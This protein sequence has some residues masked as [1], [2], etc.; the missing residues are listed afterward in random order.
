MRIKT[1]ISTSHILIVL[2]SLALLALLLAV[3]VESLFTDNLRK[4]L[5]KRAYSIAIVLNAGNYRNDE[6]QERITPLAK[7]F[8]S[9][10]TL[11]DESGR[12][13]ADSE[14][15]PR[16][17]ENHADRPEIK[18]ALTGKYGDDLRTS[19][20]LGR[21]MLY[22][23]T[24]IESVAGRRLIVRV[25]VPTTNIEETLRSIP[26]MATFSFLAIG[27]V[28]A[29][30]SLWLTRT[31]TGPISEMIVFAR[32]LAAGQLSERSVVSSEDELGE[33]SDSLNTMASSLEA[34]INELSNEKNKFELIVD[35]IADGLFLLYEDGRV[36]F[37][38]PAARRILRLKEEQIAGKR[39]D[40]IV[41]SPELSALIA[42]LI[43]EGAGS[44]GKAIE[45][46]ITTPRRRFLRVTAL[47]LR[48]AD[49]PVTTLVIAQDR[50]RQR[51]LEKVRRDFVA[52]ASH[53][54]K[55][56]IA[57]LKL[58]AE[59]LPKAVQDDPE[60]ASRF[61]GKISK[62]M[63]RLAR[64]VD[65]LLTLSSLEAPEK[66]MERRPVELADLTNEV[67]QHFSHMAEEKGLKLEIEVDDEQHVIEGDQRLLR[68]LIENLVENA[69]KYT[70][71]G[72]VAV[73]LRGGEEKVV[74]EVEDTGPGIAESDQTRIFERFYRVDKDRSRATGGTGLGLSIVK[75][76]AQNHSAAVSVKSDLDAG[77]T[78]RVEFPIPA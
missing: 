9:R 71:E 66:K 64:L 12:V 21:N 24:P 17:M 57:G 14:I 72:R 74:L 27:T 44:T 34:N 35:H 10:I 29:L 70:A 7:R 76:I 15:N 61:A 50:T 48:G 28:A 56:P 52:N 38:N 8:E 18:S 2:L 58:L 1:K 40:S 13:L 60:A 20:T 25:A 37:A 26:S 53:E 3:R 31:F 47:P 65:D 22:V 75:H 45:I 19:S 73:R 69:V 68:T 32:R 59:T 42:G 62:D 16:N 39:L 41:D 30:I 23:A 33:L 63:D 6:L 46:G 67:V 5:Q 11:V 36:L 55:T 51:R 43:K 49:D 54:L 4:E 77:S 78:F